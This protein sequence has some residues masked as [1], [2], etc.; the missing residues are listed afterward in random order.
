MM[1]RNLL[2]AALIFCCTSVFS[3]V[4]IYPKVGM[5]VSTQNLFFGE[6]VSREDS[7]INN[8]VGMQVGFGI[9]K[10]L[11]QRVA[12]SADI[13]YTQ[14]G[15]I[16]RIKNENWSI[17]EN[18]YKLNYLISPVTVKYYVTNLPTHPFFLTAGAYGGIFINGKFI[19]S[20][21]NLF[22]PSGSYSGE[23][24]F[25]ANE[26][27]DYDML[28]WGIILGA[29]VNFNIGKSEL[30]IQSSYGLGMSKVHEIQYNS[31]A[32]GTHVYGA[33]GK[34]RFLAVNLGYTLPT[35]KRKSNSGA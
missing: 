18:G 20:H 22:Y 35:W 28:D 31:W 15:Y 34:N 12:L 5:V 17:N 33:D 32:R 23:I 13:L 25:S 24:K 16:D 19:Y 2:M 4:K 29:G 11:S 30:L 8:R 14:L 1:K 9:E 7:E 26:H 27:N 21:K 10:S 6:G 3:Q